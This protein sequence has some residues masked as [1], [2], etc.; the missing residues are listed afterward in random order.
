M[1]SKIHHKINKKTQNTKNICF[2]YI[3]LGI[4]T[5][6]LWSLS[7]FLQPISDNAKVRCSVISSS[8]RMHNA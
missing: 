6:V 5:R 7:A 4:T 2:L 3:A 1:I 8:A